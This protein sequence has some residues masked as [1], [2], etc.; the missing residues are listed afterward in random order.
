MGDVPVERICPRCSGTHVVKNGHRQGRQQYRCRS[1][2]CG[3][4]FADRAEA[5]GHQF[6]AEAIATAIE[7]HL[8]GRPYREIAA[9]LE[10]HFSISDTKISGRTI[11]SW[12][13]K[14]VNIAGEEGRKPPVRTVGPWRVEYSSLH[15]VKGGC[16]IVQDL[17]TSHVLAAQ[18]GDSF[19]PA[20]AAELIRIFEASIGNLSDNLH[21]LTFGTDVDLGSVEDFQ[22]VQEAIKRLFPFGD[23]IPYK[24]ILVISRPYGIFSPLSDFW[25]PLQIMRKPKAFRSPESRQLFLDGWVAM[26][27]I[28]DMEDD[29]DGPVPAE[30]AGPEAPF[31]SW[32]DAVNYRVKA[33]EEMTGWEWE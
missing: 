5:P 20:V 30:L 27:N 32:L 28:F 26:H 24:D 16:W 10:Q 1:I 7:L 2:G 23:Y 11:Y 15:P 17:A 6:P 9:D 12:V 31:R 18:A 21:F 4:Q 33:Q 3:Y 13:R 22:D 19:D 29:P 14:Y 8:L 25:Y